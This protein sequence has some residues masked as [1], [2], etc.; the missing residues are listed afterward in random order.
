MSEPSAA[1]APALVAK[2]LA[3]V[4]NIIVVGENDVV[5]ANELQEK[6][7]DP[8]LALVTTEK[9]HGAAF[10][11]ENSQFITIASCT[12]KGSFVLFAGPDSSVTLE[13]V[14]VS[15]QTEELGE[16]S[17]NVPLAYVVS[18]GDK[19]SLRNASE[20]FDDLIKRSIAT[21]REQ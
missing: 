15:I 21:W 13:D 5:R 8:F 9:E 2:R 17:Y 7:L 10:G 3:C 16:Y 11:F 12:V 14:N 19:F 1:L 6:N 4:G 20:I 18:F